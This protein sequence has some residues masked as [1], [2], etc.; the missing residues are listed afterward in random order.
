MQF[1]GVNGRRA[2]SWTKTTTTSD[3]GSVS[4]STLFG[5]GKTVLRGGYGIF[6]PSIFFRNFLGDT[7][8]FSSLAP[9]MSLRAPG[10]KAFQFSKGFPYAPVESP[11][12]AAG[13]SALLGQA[14]SLLRVR[15]NDATDAAM[16][17]GVQQQIGSWLVDATYA[18]NK[19]NH[20][21]GW[22]QPESDRSADSPATGPVIE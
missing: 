10:L 19:G 4:L 16:E 13:P 11:G 18:A 12:A 7:T 17:F 2:P 9:A 20:S 3:L 15:R 8:L 1:A 14:V 5:T 6:Y 22:L 21:G